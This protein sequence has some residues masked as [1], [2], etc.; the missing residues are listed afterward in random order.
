MNITATAFIGVRATR[1]DRS[2]IPELTELAP[3]TVFDTLK[4]D[5]G[6]DSEKER[7]QGGVRVGVP[8]P[9]NQAAVPVDL[10]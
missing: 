8:V 7:R 3:I 4:F 10:V 1:Q 2:Q 5:Y 6:G 9:D